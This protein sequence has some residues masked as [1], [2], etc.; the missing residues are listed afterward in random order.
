MVGAQRWF[1]DR[2]HAPGPALTVG[3]Q[4]A[5]DARAVGALVVWTVHTSANPDRGR[6]PAMGLPRAGTVDA[7]LAMKPAPGVVIVS[8]GGLDAFHAGTLDGVLRRAGR[9]LLILVGAGLET[10]VHSTLRSANDRGYECLVL[11]DGVACVEPTNAAGAL[12]SICMSGGIFGAIADSR[13]LKAALYPTASHHSI[14]EPPCP[15]FR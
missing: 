2:C 12:S 6:R 8:A 5:T 9:P 7:R 13:S 1:I 10:V 3:G 15:S 11:V 4:A 14:M